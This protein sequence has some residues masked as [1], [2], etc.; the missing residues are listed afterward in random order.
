[1][2][3]CMHEL[4]IC[5]CEYSHEITADMITS[6]VPNNMFNMIMGKKTNLWMMRLE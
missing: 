4:C 6:I 2:H 3:L 5:T 1:M